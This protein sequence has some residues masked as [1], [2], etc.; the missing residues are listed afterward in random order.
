MKIIT[1]PAAAIK[2]LIINNIIGVACGAISK[3]VAYKLPE[4]K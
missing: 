4:G 1:K 2:I 3:P